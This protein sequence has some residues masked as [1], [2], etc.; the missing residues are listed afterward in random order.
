MSIGMYCKSVLHTIRCPPGESYVCASN[1]PFRKVEYSSVAPPS[2]G[3]RKAGTGG[4]TVARGAGPGP[5]A[6]GSGSG[7]GP[8]PGPGGSSLGRESRDFVRPKLVTVVRG[9]TRPRRAVRVLLNK[10]TAHS[11]SQVLSDINNAFK[12]EAGA[13]RKLYTLDGKQVRRVCAK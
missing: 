11:F 10:K 6:S 9:G 3:S 2:W 5:G 13:I 8:G 1:Q 7:S 12:L 4:G